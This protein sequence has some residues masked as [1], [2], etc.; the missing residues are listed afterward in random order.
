MTRLGDVCAI[1]YG[2]DHKKLSDG[3]IPTYGS[4]GIMRYVDTA[5]CEQPSVLIPRK[6]TLGNLFY[7]DEPFW[8][9]DTL[10][11]TDI[12]Q[13]KIVPKYLYYQLK[14]KDLASYNVGTAVPSLTVEVLNEIDLDVPSIDKQRR[15]VEVLNSFDSKIA[16]NNQLND[17]LEQLVDGKFQELFG[18]L[19]F[20]A[21]LSDVAEITMGQSPAGSSYNEEGAGIIFYQGRGEFG[22]RFPKRRLYTTEPK[23]L[24]CEGDVLMSVRAPVGDL[25]VAFE[26]CCIGRGLA[27][28]HSETPSF[29]L[30]LMRFLKP[31]LEAYNGEGTVFGSI[32]GKALKSL[33]VALPSHN[34][35][36]QFE[37]F[38]APIDALIRS[39]ENET[40]KLNNLRNYLLPKLM[41]GEIDVSKVDLTQL[42]NNHL[43]ARGHNVPNCY[44]KD[45]LWK[46]SLIVFCRRCRTCLIR[47][48]SNIWPKYSESRC[49]QLRKHQRRRIC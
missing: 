49:C 20:N 6:G 31:Q 14:Q 16:L 24:A 34:E 39:N 19:N 44:W 7:T 45:P 1:R 9:V 17:Y 15:I 23:R 18:G 21:T 28:I 47:H 27:A 36:M 2:K 8:T 26:N 11:W 38:A 10:F 32:N 33:E 5:I 30:Y 37:S 46:P 48:S 3:S 41:S 13:T 40:R 4:G 12:D 22:W 35:V 29:A 43:P 25:N 42:T